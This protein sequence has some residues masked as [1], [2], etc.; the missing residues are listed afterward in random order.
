MIV[1]PAARG[2]AAAVASRWTRP[3]AMT[4]AIITTKARPRTTP[5]SELSRLIAV[6]RDLRLELVEA[7]VVG[8]RVG[9]GAPDRRAAWPVAGPWSAAS[10]WSVVV[11]LTVGSFQG[12]VGPGP[13]G[14]HAG[15]RGWTGV[16]R[17]GRCGGGGRGR[18][19]RARPSRAAATKAAMAAMP[20]IMPMVDQA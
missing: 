6:A 4:E 7:L 12:G 20:A 10:G 16:R 9:A 14:A 19:R 1:W 2:G 11:W 15:R 8:D 18:G 17:S 13:P 3:T 5:T